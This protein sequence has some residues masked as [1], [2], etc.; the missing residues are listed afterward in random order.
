VFPGGSSPAGVLERDLS[1]VLDGDFDSAFPGGSNPAGVLERDLSGVLD[2]DFDSAFP[3]SSNPAGVLE[4]DLSGILDGDFDSAFAGG[5][6]PAGVLERDLSGVLDGDFDSAFP[7]GSNPAGVLERDLSGVL[8]G[9]FDSVFPGG[10]KP[11]GVLERDLSGVLDGV[12]SSRSAFEDVSRRDG[13]VDRE[14][15][16]DF[17]VIKLCSILPSASLDGLLD[18]LISSVNSGTNVVLDGR[19]V[20]LSNLSFESSMAG[21]VAFSMSLLDGGLSVSL[22][23]FLSSLFIAEESLL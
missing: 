8:N 1:G 13:V 7:G 23:S 18:F 22:S 20:L 5:S 16:E 6:N 14:L 19:D 11:A 17:G 10:S 15:S 12:F 4:R 9:D 21:E 2:G 3:G